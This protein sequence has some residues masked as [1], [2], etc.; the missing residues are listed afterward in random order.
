MQTFQ[1]KL[2]HACR[3]RSI[4]INEL[5]TKTKIKPL[6]LHLA[7]TGQK[8]LSNNDM[9]ALCSYFDLTGDYFINPAIR[10]VDVESFPKEERD[11]LIKH[12]IHTWIMHYC[13]V[14]EDD[15]DR[16]FKELIEI[17]NKFKDLP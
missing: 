17:L 12:N 13:L 6:S 10:C 7:I 9:V 4:T 14:N 5:C 1:Q 2:D 11:E 8:Y 3:T 15:P 16:S